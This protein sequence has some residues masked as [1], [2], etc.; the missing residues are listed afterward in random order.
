M[1]PNR[2]ESPGPRPD[3]AA[4]QQAATGCT[5]ACSTSSST[6]DE[7]RQLRLGAVVALV[8]GRE[9]P[10]LFCCTVLCPC[11]PALPCHPTD[12][13]PTTNCTPAHPGARPRSACRLSSSA[14]NFQPVSGPPTPRPYR[15]P[16]CRALLLGRRPRKPK[17]GC[18]PVSPAD[19][20]GAQRSNVSIMVLGPSAG[21]AN[22]EARTAN[23]HLQPRWDRGGARAVSLPNRSCRRTRNGGQSSAR[24]YK[25]STGPR[26][27]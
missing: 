4:V 12:T 2:L 15:R 11:D 22:T 26:L 24:V 20:A 8:P 1:T 23:I 19:A 17:A 14:L 10:P 27:D 16:A 21:H 25:V 18:A 3:R 9:S 5:R 7:R 13:L 6:R